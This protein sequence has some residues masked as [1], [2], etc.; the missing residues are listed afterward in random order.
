MDGDIV[1][2][3]FDNFGSRL[4]GLMFYKEPPYSYVLLEPC[5]SIHTFFMKFPI[6]AAFLDNEGMIVKVV[7]NLEKNKIILP[8]KNAHSV[9]ETKSGDTS[10]FEEG[11]YLDIIS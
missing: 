6:D 11:M 9:I 4:R 8:V 2:K 5:N 10:I 7:K 3:R 1:V